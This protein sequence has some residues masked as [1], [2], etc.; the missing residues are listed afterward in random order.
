MDKRLRRKGIFER[1]IAKQLAPPPKFVEDEDYGGF[2]ARNFVIHLDEDYGGFWA[3]NFVIHLS[4][5]SDLD[6][7]IGIEE[8]TCIFGGEVFYD[9]TFPMG[10]YEAGEVERFMY[11]KNFMPEGAPF[12]KFSQV[13]PDSYILELDRFSP[14]GKFYKKIYVD[15]FFRKEVKI[16]L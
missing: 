5:K 11:A 12:T 4:G 15:M 6:T 2:W 1:Q 3:R 10:L 13:L 7:R 16:Y 8:K 14:K 9:W